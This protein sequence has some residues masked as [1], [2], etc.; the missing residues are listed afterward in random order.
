M[1]KL[2][3]ALL[4][5]LFTLVACHSMDQSGNASATPSAAELP[6]GAGAA[7]LS[8]DAPTTTT[9]GGPLTNLSG[10]RIYY[11]VNADD[12][13]Q[14]VQ[15]TGIGVE[16]YVIDNLGQ[17]TWYFAIRAV[18]SAGAESPLSDVVSKTID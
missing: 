1:S 11:G 3:S 8:W 14:I 15:L 5:S 6:T 9:S 10:Y 2:I 12:L 18:T 17:G 13:S 4:L 7:T 16:T